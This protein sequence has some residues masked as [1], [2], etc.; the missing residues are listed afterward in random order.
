MV[1]NELQILNGQCLLFSRLNFYSN[2]SLELSCLRLLQLATL[3]ARD[4][5]VA[6][7]IFILAS[8]KS[9]KHVTIDPTSE[10]ETKLMSLVKMGYCLINC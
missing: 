5:S 8:D 4:R 2:Y 1:G 6:G 9:C 10:A 7:L 3:L